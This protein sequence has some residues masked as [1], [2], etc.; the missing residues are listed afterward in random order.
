M[1]AGHYAPVLDRLQLPGA[2]DAIRT[3]R[4]FEPRASRGLWEC[5]L[6]PL[7]GMR[8]VGGLI[9]DRFAVSWG[10]WWFFDHDEHELRRMWRYMRRASPFF[11]TRPPLFFGV[12]EAVFTAVMGVA[13]N[14]LRS[15]AAIEPV[16]LPD[17]T[18]S[19][20]LLRDGTVLGP[21]DYFE[22]IGVKDV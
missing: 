3:L 16:N 5:V 9:P 21:A 11:L 13:R 7:K 4:P 12:Q 1:V 2:A 19:L 10:P 8:F 20:S 15:A 17:R 14:G 6:G 18:G 22:P